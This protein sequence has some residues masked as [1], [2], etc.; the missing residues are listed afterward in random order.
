MDKKDLDDILND[1]IFDISDTEKELFKLQEPIKKAY[2]K[3]RGNPDDV[4]KRKP[5]ADFECYRPLFDKVHTELKNGIRSLVKYHEDAIRKGIFYYDDGVMAY[6]EDVDVRK[7]QIKDRVRNDGRSHVIY[8]NGTESNPLFR[9]IGKVITKGGYVIT[10]PTGSELNTFITDEA[11]TSKDIPTGW[12]YVLR[13]LSK[14]HEIAEVKDLYKIGFSTTPVEE[15]IKNSIHEPTYLMDKVEIISTYKVYNMN[16]HYLETLIH[17]FFD[18]AR[19]YVTVKD[20]NGN[21]YQPEEWFIVPI[22]IIKDAI[23][24]MIDHSIVNYT[25]NRDMQV[26]EKK[27]Q[28]E[29]DS[30]PDNRI[31]SPKYDTRDLAVLS[32]IIKQEYFDEIM[33]GDKEIEY[34][35]LKATKLKQY[36]ELDESTGKRYIRRYNALRL[37][38]GYNKDR[39]MLLVELKDTTFDKNNSVI[40]YHLGKILEYN[41]KKKH[42]K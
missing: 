33:S 20:D 8:E 24:R 17:H 25:Y 16:V 14:N 28:I 1:H 37:Y 35:E 22:T 13:S 15:R 27:Q 23:Q 39:D 21:S 10:E 6:V 41:I 31:I 18:S 12:I 7:R 32:L 40:E 11:L 19:F 34:R 26:L 38:A 4:A 9:T 3:H 2:I 42:S 5:C 36:T 30:M 29:I